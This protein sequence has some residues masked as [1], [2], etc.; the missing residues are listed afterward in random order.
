[1]AHHGHDAAPVM[2]DPRFSLKTYPRK[3]NIFQHKKS[4]DFDSMRG[5]LFVERK[6]DNLEIIMEWVSF[7]VI[8]VLTGLTAA[9]MSHLEEK[10]TI[11]RNFSQ[12]MSFP[13]FANKKLI[14]PYLQRNLS[15]LVLDFFFF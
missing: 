5:K 3:D 2:M 13:R 10:I 1:M 4:L 9:I 11:F 12:Q 15:F 14:L 7:S 8:G 6:R